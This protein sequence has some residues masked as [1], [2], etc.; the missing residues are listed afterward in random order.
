MPD[1]ATCAWM[2]LQ[3]PCTPIFCL[4]A[5]GHAG[6]MHPCPPK[7]IA[8]FTCHRQRPTSAHLNRPSSAA[9]PAGAPGHGVQVRALRQRH[10]GCSEGPRNRRGPRRVCI[11]GVRP[12]GGRPGPRQGLLPG[13]CVAA[14]GHCAGTVAVIQNRGEASNVDSG[15]CLGSRLRNPAE[16]VW[17]GPSLGLLPGLCVA[18]LAAGHC[19]GG[20]RSGEAGRL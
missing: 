10:R 15:Q 8:S 6:A 7:G 20:R 9:E 1:A 12:P 3:L 5:C 18:A 13:L 16:A 17:P 14:V 11:P 19:A 4:L 2:A